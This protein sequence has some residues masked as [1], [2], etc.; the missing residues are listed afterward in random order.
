[1]QLLQIVI[2]KNITYSYWQK[3][4]HTDRIESFL[5]FHEHSSYDVAMWNIME[6]LLDIFYI[7]RNKYFGEPQLNVF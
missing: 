6:I 4:P 1:M 7:G 3:Q 5:H 2:N